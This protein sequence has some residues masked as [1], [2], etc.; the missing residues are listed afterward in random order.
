MDSYCTQ[1]EIHDVV[2]VHNPIRKYMDNKMNRIFGKAKDE[3]HKKCLR[4]TMQHDQ[5]NHSP[6]LQHDEAHSNE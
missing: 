4:V 2:L 3:W 6:G 1:F 5:A